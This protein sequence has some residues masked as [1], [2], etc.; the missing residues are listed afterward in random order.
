M[1]KIKVLSLF[2]L[3]AS[4][5]INSVAQTNPELAFILSYQALDNFARTISSD[6]DDVGALQLL[7]FMKNCI[8][9]DA[10]QKQQIAAAKDGYLAKGTP[11]DPVKIAAQ[12]KELQARIE[13]LDHNIKEFKKGGITPKENKKVDNRRQER[14]EKEAL[15]KKNQA[16]LAAQNAA[17][18]D[19]EQ[20]AQAAQAL[21]D[22]NELAF[23]Q[24]L[25]SY[26]YSFGQAYAKNAS[27]VI[28]SKYNKEMPI[29]PKEYAQLVAT[30]KNAANQFGSSVMITLDLDNAAPANIQD[31]ISYINNMAPASAS[32]LSYAGYALAATAVTAAVIAAAAVSYNVY[33]G[34]DWN[35][36][37]DAQDA[38]NTGLG[39]AKSGYNVIATSAA[40]VADQSGMNE[41]ANRFS[42]WV[43]SVANSD[44]VKYMEQQVNQL[45][46]K[47][48]MVQDQQNI[49]TAN[50][51]ASNAPDLA[52]NIAAAI[53]ETSDQDGAE[54][55]AG[56]IGK[57]EDGVELNA[58]ESNWLIKGAAGL[59]AVAGSVAAAKIPAVRNALRN[60]Q[61]MPSSA[62]QVMGAANLNTAASQANRN[63]KV[64]A[65]KEQ[66]G[67]ATAKEVQAADIAAR[68]AQQIA[69]T[70]GAPSMWS[71]QVQG[72]SL[73]GNPAASAMPVKLTPSQIKAQ[74]NIA[75][76]NAANAAQ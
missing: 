2:M 76:Y 51:L 43:S 3:L 33:Q 34:K 12:N 10:Q 69:N 56:V 60:A 53:G 38:Y 22:Q 61:F 41:A 62:S 37:S 28:S 15:I 48:A 50:D 14:K 30:L 74:Q 17:M 7:D 4:A 42:S 47:P 65:M 46:G 44:A 67:L 1:K 63:F 9:F 49:N 23:E 71:Q 70:P 16:A 26:I 18:A 54:M 25:E 68:N 8:A 19:A 13:T 52:E 64:V 72:G 5:Q 57:I 40:S 29:T 66:F 6:R 73:V 39:Q 58:E 31:V 59:T 75:N 11:L 45:R 20:K 32:F 55:A 36:T 27:I 21:I 35:D 24:A